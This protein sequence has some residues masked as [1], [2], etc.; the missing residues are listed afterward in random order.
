MIDF[1]PEGQL[2]NSTKNK[3]AMFS[4]DSLY[5]AY[6]NNEILEARA[7]LCDKK[8]N[9][10]VDLGCLQGIIPR[11]EGAIGISDGRVKDIALIS[12]VNKAVSFTISSFKKDKNGKDI[13]ILS[14]KSAQEKCKTEYIS[15]LRSGDVI[16]ARITHLES[17]G[18]FADIGCGIISLIPIDFISISRIDH[19]RE[20][21]TVDMDINA[22]VKGYNNDRICLSHKE[23]LGSWSENAEM[24]S[25]GETVTGIVRSVEDYGIFIEL[26]PNLA[27]LAEYHEN[28]KPK[29]LVSVYIK[30]II[31]QKMKIKL[32][33][34]NTFEERNALMNP[35]YF[36]KDKHM[37][38]FLY[39]PAC[40]EKIIET[41]FD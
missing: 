28:I 26:M 1:Y 18:A 6:K 33:I 7:I 5:E 12:R 30:N 38:H 9:L 23:L 22:I 31:P 40:C 39:S 35:K 19:P 8:H 17:F 14:R 27:G 21:F 4:K 10:I 29:Q 34:I 15:N 16:K 32:V 36:F 24:F 3:N 20:R 41:N 25:P 11:D 2:I 37:D 13:A